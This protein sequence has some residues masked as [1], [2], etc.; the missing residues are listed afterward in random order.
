MKRDYLSEILK[1]AREQ[2]DDVRIAVV[3]E[4]L[5]AVLENA[6]EGGSFSYFLQDRLGLPAAAYTQLYLAGGM[7]VTNAFA[8][9]DS[10]GPNEL[11]EALAVLGAMAGGA[12][13]E[14][15][16]ELKRANGEPV[17]RPSAER[18]A[19]FAAF[20]AAVELTESNTQL[21]EANRRLTERCEKLEA[22]TV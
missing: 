20:H 16:P 6:R 11:P 17:L 8:L 7:T 5:R 4:T 3:A 18:L 2:P 12:P 15:H 22:G 10:N 1:F 9:P 14:P 19:L 21:Q 13:L